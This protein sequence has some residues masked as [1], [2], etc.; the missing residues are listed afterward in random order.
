[1]YT[2]LPIARSVSVFQ[3]N[4]GAVFTGTLLAQE[5]FNS[6]LKSDPSKQFCIINTGSTSARGPCKEFPFYSFA[7][8]SVNIVFYSI[9]S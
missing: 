1:M 4:L 2:N 6:Q 8:N 3:I 5:H 7:K 9:I